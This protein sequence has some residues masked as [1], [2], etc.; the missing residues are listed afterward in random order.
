[1]PGFDRTGPRGEGPMTGGGMGFCAVQLPA[2]RPVASKGTGYTGRF[3]RFHPAAV[4][5]S[6]LDFLKRR[7][8]EMEQYLE[9]IEARVREL[10]GE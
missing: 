8:V 3:P 10:A 6:E 9:K 5:G 4:Q 1:M 2:G 7:A